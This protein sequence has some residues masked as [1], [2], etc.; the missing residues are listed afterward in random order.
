[1][2]TTLAHRLPTPTADLQ[3]YLRAVHAFPYLSADEERELATRFRRDDDLDAA[4]RLVTSHLRYVAKVARGYRGYGLPQEDLIQEGNIG[5]MKAVKRFDP[6]VGVRL[7]SF[8]MH[9]IRAEIH[10]FVLRNWR[11]VRVATT[12]AQRKLFFNLR[13]AK[14]RLGAL[15]REEIDEI[16]SDLAVRP[17]D[18]IEMERRLE[19]HDSAFDGLVDDEDHPAP[20]AFIADPALD[21][22]AAV[23]EEEWS[24]STARQ[25]HLALEN[26]DERTRDIVRRRWL[27]EPKA[28]LRELAEEYGVSAERIRQV[29]AQALQDLKRALAE[30][31]P[32]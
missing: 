23:E 24:E 32:G 20:A 19:A 3:G 14:Q 17:E 1:M 13:G 15:S 18:V 29:E 26:L 30:A 11:I 27:T 9:W 28:K 25:L 8:A 31:V 5:L 2:T 21:P 22:S 10:E 16:A 4:W 6:A 12:K 7:V